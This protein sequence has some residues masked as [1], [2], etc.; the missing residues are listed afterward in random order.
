MK[1]DFR[2]I[3]VEDLAGNVDTIDVSKAFGNAIFNNACDRG[4]F[5]L[6]KPIYHDGEIDI[7]EEQAKS[8]VKYTEVFKLV[9]YREAVKNALLN[10]KDEE[11]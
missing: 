3:K 4:E 7:T 9:V 11:K 10:I 8:L 2:K 1:I 5:D 6:S